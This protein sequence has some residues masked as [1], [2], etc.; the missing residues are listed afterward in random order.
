MKSF[1]AN[2]IIHF[3]NKQI[4]GQEQAKQSLSVLISNK[5]NKPALYKQMNHS[6]MLLVGPAGIGKASLV[7]AAA[8]FLQSPIV[9]ISALSLINAHIMDVFKNLVTEL[10]EAVIDNKRSYWKEKYT[11]N[12]ME[13]SKDKIIEI[14]AQMTN[15]SA[16]KIRKKFNKNKYNNLMIPI[17]IYYKSKLGSNTHVPVRDAITILQEHELEKMLSLHDFAH[18]A[19]SEAQNTGIV[20]IDDLD[21]LAINPFNNHNISYSRQLEIC[22]KHITEFIT[23][24]IISTKYGNLNTRHLLCICMG[25]FN[26]THVTHLRPELQT[27]LMNIS[28]CHELTSEDMLLILTTLDETIL[29][30]YLEILK[31][32]NIDVSLDIEALSALCDCAYKQNHTSTNLGIMRLYSLLDKLFEP[33]FCYETPSKPKQLIISSAEILNKFSEQEEFFDSSRYIL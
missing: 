21:K 27:H 6:T 23:G 8:K 5:Y 29:H 19:I 2:D 7:K 20:I 4:I 11:S 3:L 14:I 15:E 26:E 9:R 1:T 32:K 17:G 12:A 22:Q 16:D 33:F 25:Y 13:L 30:K 24:I 18:E 10:I 28:Y 31:A